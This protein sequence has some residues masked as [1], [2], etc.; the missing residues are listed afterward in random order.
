[1]DSLPTYNAELHREE[2]LTKAEKHVKEARTVVTKKTHMGGIKGGS[3]KKKK[4]FLVL[5]TASQGVS[6]MAT[7][8]HAWQPEH[9]Y[10]LPT[11][12]RRGRYT[13]NGRRS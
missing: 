11:F 12:I 4:I 6:F 13:H 3:K 9:T 2:V 8:V 1:M 10:S 7:H 5:P